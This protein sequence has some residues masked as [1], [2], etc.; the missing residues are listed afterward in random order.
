MLIEYRKRTY[1]C[2]KI[3][4]GTIDMY[5]GKIL[6][7][8]GKMGKRNYWFSPSGEGKYFTIISD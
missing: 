4:Y 2:E 3:N 6:F 7:K 1:Q 5:R 8:N